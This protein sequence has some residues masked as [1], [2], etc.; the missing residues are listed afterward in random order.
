[1][2]PE[3]EDQLYEEL[4]TQPDFDCLPLPAHWFRKYSI[5]AR[6][7]INS[8]EYIESNYCVE[9]QLEQKD[10]PPFIVDEPVDGGRLV[11]VPHE[12]PVTLEV[13]NKPFQWDEKRPFPA[14]LPAIAEAIE[15]E[16]KQD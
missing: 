7:V 1:M 8:R 15:K 16:Q 5:P 4:R 10:L 9:K 2:T 3:E 11:T 12:E 6:A 14:V 13:I